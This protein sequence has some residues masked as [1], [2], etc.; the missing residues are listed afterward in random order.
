M[1][2][3]TTGCP[4]LA[5]KDG[6]MLHFCA[7][8]WATLVN[9]SHDR[10]WLQHKP[11]GVF[12]HALNCKVETATE[13]HATCQD[14]PYHPTSLTWDLCFASIGV[15]QLHATVDFICSSYQPM[16]QKA[17]PRT[18]SS[19]TETLTNYPQKQNGPSPQ[20]LNGN[21]RWSASW[22]HNLQWNNHLSGS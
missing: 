10:I 19:S 6:P 14:R 21:T 9:D 20:G 2:F 4:E 16:C 18:W 12:I 15:E 8:G 17:I 13:E 5:G 22:N 1:L 11:H 7:P 3:D